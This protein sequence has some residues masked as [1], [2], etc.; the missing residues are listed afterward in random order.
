[1]NARV[2]FLADNAGNK[3]SGSTGRI[4]VPKLAVV[5]K[6]NSAF[7]FVIKG[8]KV[9]QRA[10]RAGGEIGDDYHVLEGLSGNESVA[11]N[12]VD[13]LRDGDRVKVQ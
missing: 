9:E 7:V 2:N 12:G 1:M 5:R 13:K 10:I 11:L 8:D 6:D 4:L 3:E